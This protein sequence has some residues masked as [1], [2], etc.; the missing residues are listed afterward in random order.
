MATMMRISE[1]IEHLALAFSYIKHLLIAKHNK[2][3]GIHSPFIY[4]LVSK[5]IHD[6]QYYSEY[7][8]LNDIRKELIS[9]SEIVDVVELGARSE[10]FLAGKRKISDMAVT[11][12][13]NR[14]IG[15]LLFRLVRFYKPGI[16]IE[17]GT[18]VGISTIYLAKGNAAS[19][20]ISLEGIKSLSSFADNLFERQGIRNIKVI[21]GVFGE[22]LDKI[23]TEFPAPGLVFIDGNHNY[24]ATL[25]YF[26]YFCSIMEEGIMV[27]DDIRW[28]EGMRKAWHTIV[29]DARA[30]VTIDLFFMGIVVRRK[31]ITPGHYCIRF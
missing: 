3:H 1:L 8:Y 24:L 4:E 6:K 29:N 23:A 15:R 16:V 14:K 31:S 25:D 21:N 13:V 28:S 2:G 30:H 26:G 11:S 18:S 17:L 9:S 27:F 20:I 19:A 7:S 12:S 10:H 22:Q 5:V